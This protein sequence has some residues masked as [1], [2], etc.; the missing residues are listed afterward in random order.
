MVLIVNEV[1]YLIVIVVLE[2][3]KFARLQVLYIQLR[4]LIVLS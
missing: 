2:C 4:E 3:L 1:L